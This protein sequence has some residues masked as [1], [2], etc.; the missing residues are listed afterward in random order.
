MGPAV[1]GDWLSVLASDLDSCHVVAPICLASELAVHSRPSNP[2]SLKHCCGTFVLFGGVSV[3]TTVEL[4]PLPRRLLA[5]QSRMMLDD[6]VYGL[7]Q[8]RVLLVAGLALVP[9]DERGGQEPLDVAA[10]VE[11]AIFH[12]F[13]N[14]GAEYAAKVGTHLIPHSS[15]SQSGLCA[16]KPWRVTS[17]RGA[18]FS[19]AVVGPAVSVSSRCW[20]SCR[21]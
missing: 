19:M 4:L 2:V 7:L 9:D 10:E 11:T 5:T 20:K 17:S 21:L 15:R 6:T 12:K 8:V 3:G 18:S 1:A 16:S 14:A 13:G